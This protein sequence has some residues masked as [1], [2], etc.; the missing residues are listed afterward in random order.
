MCFHVPGSCDGH[1][2]LWRCGENFR[3]L[4][5]LFTIPAPGF[6]NALAFTSS[7]NSRKQQSWSL[8]AGMGQEHR[9]GRWQRIKEAKNCVLVIP[10][11][12]T[13]EIV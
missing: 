11:E 8:A 7:S 4:S 10:L 12:T 2:R 5:P 9:L 6:V 13:E 1:I 3:S